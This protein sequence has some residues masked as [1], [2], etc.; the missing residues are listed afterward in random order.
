[1]TLRTR[2]II[3]F[4]FIAI[5]F[6]A[7]PL[8]LLYT[9]GYRYNLK[10][11]KIIKTGL[12][13]IRTTPKD[14]NVYLDGQLQP[15]QPTLLDTYEQ[16]IT[17]LPPKKYLLEIKKD[18]YFDWR[19]NLEVRPNQTTFAKTVLL[20]KKNTPWS[21]LEKQ[22]IL[23]KIS[24]D[25][26]RLALAANNEKQDLVYIYSTN[27]DNLENIPLKINSDKINN[28][29]WSDSSKKIIIRTAKDI[30][31]YNLENRVT[32]SLKEI[33]IDNLHNSKINI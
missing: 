16:R 21:I 6:I 4:S 17:D 33:I 25:K 31:I 19:K 9:S 20:L 14:V 27:S 12:L 11:G 13:V 32:K 18:G 7:A 29:E 23:T 30:Y 15:R 28:I 26:K 8:L 1:M 24:P 10:R 22:V 2:R 5:F 3:M